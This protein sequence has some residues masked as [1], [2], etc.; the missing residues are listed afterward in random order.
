MRRG[1]QPKDLTGQRFG[2]LQALWPAWKTKRGFMW[3]CQCDDGN[4]VYIA[5]AQL[6]SEH[7]KSCGC[8]HLECLARNAQRGHGQSRSPEYAIYKA[9]KQ[10][11]VNPNDAAYPDYG[12]RGI[13]FLFANFEEFVA[14][15]GPRPSPELTL[16]RINND[17]NYEAG[18]IRWATRLDQTR[19]RRT[20]KDSIIP[21]LAS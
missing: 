11:C 10:R 3:A 15:L 21:A 17:G 16:D 14:Q 6:L 9:A 20:R 12:G 1:G 19:N 2:R 13:K 8:L 5:V 4:I 18:N 7:T